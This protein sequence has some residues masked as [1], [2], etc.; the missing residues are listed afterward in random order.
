MNEQTNQSNDVFLLTREEVRFLMGLLGAKSLLGTD[1]SPSQKHRKTSLKAR[2]ALL[3]RGWIK[4]T[5][6]RDQ[7]NESILPILSTVF[8]PT[9]AL[10]VVRDLPQV[11]QQVLIFLRRQQQIILHTFPEERAHRLESFSS[12]DKVADMLLKWFPLHR[13][14]S[15]EASFLIPIDQFEHFKTLVEANQKQNAINVLKN[16]A[17]SSQDQER[18]IQTIVGRVLS[19]SLAV[20]KIVENKIMDAYSISVL[21]GPNSAWVITQPEDNSDT[22]AM[23]RV[24]RIGTA[25]E[26]VVQQ[27]VQKFG[28]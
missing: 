3:E 28:E 10:M 1:L 2:T 9:S 14:P 23:L 4:A 12:I 15:G 24:Q 27:L 7:I 5:G 25:F 11:G 22:V 6:G 19:G 21:A 17:V 18:L 16:S 8:F 26:Q 13:F 20:L